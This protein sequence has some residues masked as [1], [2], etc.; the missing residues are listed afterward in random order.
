MT[1]KTMTASTASKNFG[2]YIDA[3]R[4]EP[5]VV[6]RQNRPVA[7]TFSIEDAE[8]LLRSKIDAGI[9]RGLADIETGRVLEPETTAQR[10]S[11]YQ[12]RIFQQAK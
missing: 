3:A 1:M 2:E 4:R 7:V 12:E 6:T 5:V 8:E 10:I 11:R 9:A